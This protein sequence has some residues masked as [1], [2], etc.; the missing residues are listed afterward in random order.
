MKRL[1]DFC[2]YLLIK[3]G[4]EKI[5][6]NNYR[7]TL[8]KF[9]RDLKTEQPS[10][11]EAEKYIGQIIKNEYS[12]SHIINSSIAVER[13][14]EFLGQPIKIARPRK[15]QT[16][17]TKDVLTEGEIAR[18]VAAT[19]NKREEAMLGVLIY[20]GLRNKEVCNLKVRDID[21]ENCLIKVIAGKFK[22]DRIIPITKECIKTIQ[23]YLRDFPRNNDYLFTT[24][25][26]DK[27]YNGWAL[28]KRIKVISKRAKI[29][30]RVYPHLLRHTLATH[31]LSKGMNIVA[32]QKVL[33]HERI[34]TTMRYIHLSPQKIQSEYQYYIPNYT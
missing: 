17:V 18:M 13:Y 12:Y 4:F 14:M 24:I 26:E 1:E 23:N 33:G 29:K 21:F 30:K 10:Q 7:K 22:K 11:E 15:P 8:N 6:I 9:I 5:T 34:E 2:D 3:K 25:V 20:G 16:L 28:R 19:I 32:V 31:L 27:K